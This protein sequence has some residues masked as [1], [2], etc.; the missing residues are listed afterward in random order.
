MRKLLF[1]ARTNPHQTVTYQGDQVTELITI[2]DVHETWRREVRLNT[3]VTCGPGSPGPMAQRCVFRS[4][5][6]VR[7]FRE[8]LAGAVALL[9][10]DSWAFK[11]ISVARKTVARLYPPGDITFG[12]ALISIKGNLQLVKEMIEAI[13]LFLTEETTTVSA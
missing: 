11:E 8:R 3:R 4:F 9:G 1:E 7:E 5:G 13:D 12:N 6:E 2:T 10:D